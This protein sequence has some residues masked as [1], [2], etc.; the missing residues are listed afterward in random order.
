MYTLGINAAFHDSAACL[1]RDGVVLAAA[2]EERFSRIKHAKRPVPFTVW[3]LPF[4]AIDYCLREAG[5]KLSDVDHVAYSLD[6]RELAY[7]PSDH[8]AINLPL[9]PSAPSAEGAGPWDPLFYLYV[10][11]A[12]RQLADGAPLHLRARF[13][14]QLRYAWHYV[15]HHLAHEASACLAAP[16]EHCAVMTLDG[17]GEAATTTYGIWRDGQLQRIKQVDMPHS[18]GM[19]YEDTTRW[20]GFLHSSDEYKV[21]ALASYGTPRYLDKFRK[22]LQI[23]N[24]GGY[25]LV[26]ADLE[27]HFGPARP[28]GGRFDARHFDVSA[29]LQKA[30]EESAVKLATWLRHR[31]GETKLAMAGGVALNCVMNARI[32]DAGLFDEVWVQPAAGD[33][34]TALGA[35]L[36]VDLRERHG[37]RAWQ[38][39]HAYLGPAYDD[40]DIEALLQWSKIPFRRMEDPAE[41]TAALLAQDQI[42][43]WFQGRME[44]GPR[45]LG[46]RSILASPINPDMKARLNELKD[47]ED[48]RPVAPVVLEERF[49]DWF[50]R[51][52]ATRKAPFMLFIYDVREEKL[53]HIPAATHVDRTARVQTVD[54][55]HNPAYYNLLKAFER[56]TGVPV[57]VNTSFNSRGQP[58]V[59]SP[60]D[61]IEAFYSTPIDAL[62]MGSYVLSKR[63]QAVAAG[64]FSQNAVRAVA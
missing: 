6:P 31:S 59:C 50:V 28:R 61:A 9:H 21:M 18:L 35:A 1:V 20:L 44:F 34:G 58:I 12:S 64:E 16:F 42:I 47:R 7:Q 32:R 8:H 51:G 2:E 19:L 60:R 30:L 54:G 63:S 38:M 40:E 26:D 15:E 33:A 48:F 43:G 25:R 46:A 53:S 23:D 17:R 45:A 3:E 29:S 52:K 10:H 41:E 13:E 11:N 22:M 36:W 56:R 14:G 55:K 5:I 24:E 39:D 37:P 57:L 4:N 27:K 62:V 49:D